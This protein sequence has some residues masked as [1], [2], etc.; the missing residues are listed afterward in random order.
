MLDFDIEFVHL[1]GVDLDLFGG[2][3]D[4]LVCVSEL[5]F[6]LGVDVDHFL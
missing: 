2:I 4:H 5:S 3:V 1:L 6:D